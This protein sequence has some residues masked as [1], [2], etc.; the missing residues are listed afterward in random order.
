MGDELSTEQIEQYKT[1]YTEEGAAFNFAL[2]CRHEKDIGAVREIMKKAGD[3]ALSARWIADACIEGRV[4]ICKL[5]AELGADFT[6]KVEDFTPLIRAM[7]L[8]NEHLLKWLVEEQGFNPESDEDAKEHLQDVRPAIRFYLRE[9]K[10]FGLD[11]LYSSLAQKYTLVQEFS[12]ESTEFFVEDS[13]HSHKYIFKEGN[14]F[15]YCCGWE[16]DCRWGD[17]SYT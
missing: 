14:E 16:E 3:E 9:Q 4:D 1:G 2:V 13:G 12:L 7:K 6:R 11:A 15:A 8:D 10:A 17:D 5:M